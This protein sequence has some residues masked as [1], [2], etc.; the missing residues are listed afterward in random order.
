MYMFVLED[1]KEGVVRGTCQVFGQVG[2]DGTF[3]V[4]PEKVRIGPPG[5][6]P[7]VPGP[8]GGPPDK[9]DDPQPGE[10]PQFG[11]GGTRDNFRPLHASL[12]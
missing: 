11:V 10:L 5:L 7:G 3:V 12:G 4:R 6:V 2:T 8:P 1:P 9:K